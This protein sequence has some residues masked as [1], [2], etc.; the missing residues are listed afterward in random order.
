MYEI[1]SFAYTS[2]SSSSSLTVIQYPLLDKDLALIHVSP[3]IFLTAFLSNRVMRQVDC[4]RISRFDFDTANEFKLVK[5]HDN[6]N[7]L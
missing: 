3:H 6:Y 1:I 7:P 2:S 5:V 4:V